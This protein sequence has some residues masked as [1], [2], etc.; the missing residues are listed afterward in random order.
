MAQAEGC[1]LCAGSCFSFSVECRG[2]VVRWLSRQPG[3][4]R[5]TYYRSVSDHHG[6]EVARQLAAEVSAY[7][8]AGREAAV[9]R[10]RE[11]LAGVR[12][13]LGSGTCPG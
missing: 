2:C 13:V 1:E 8:Q 11:R 6:A 5:Q 12:R 4:R 3:T 7:Y 10:K 9:A